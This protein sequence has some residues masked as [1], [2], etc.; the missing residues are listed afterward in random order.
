MKNDKSVKEIYSLIKSL[1]DFALKRDF[2]V[3]TPLQIYV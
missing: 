1:K 3:D 2:G